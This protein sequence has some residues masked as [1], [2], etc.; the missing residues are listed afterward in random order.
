MISCALVFIMMACV[1]LPAVYAAPVSKSVDLTATVLE[2][3]PQIAIELSTNAL[4]FGSL[5]PGNTSDPQDLR[6]TN[7]GLKA[8]DVTATASDDG[9]EPL[10][11]AGLLIDGI[12]YCD[13]STTL[14]ASDLN[15]TNLALHV[16][17]NYVGRGAVS[18]GATFWAEE[19]SDKATVLYDGTVEMYEG[20]TLDFQALDG[21][22]YS[23]L[24]MNNDMG[25]LFLAG[26]QFGASD[27]YYPN[28]MLESINGIA[29]EPW[30]DS[31][32]SW[33]IFVNDQPANNGLH[34]NVLKNGDNV[35]FYYLQWDP[36]TYQPLVETA[37]YMVNI[38]IVF[39]E[40]A[41]VADFTADVTSGNVPLTV[42]FT[43][44]STNSPTSW[45]WDF[46]DG[47]TSTEQ[48]PSHTYA[49]PGSYMVVL[50]ATSAAGSSNAIKTGFVV[51]GQAITKMNWATFQGNNYHTGVTTEQAA[52]S[53]P[54]LQWSAKASSSG[55]AGFDAAPIVADGV[56]YEIS[57]K[58]SVAAYDAITGALLWE[59]NDLVISTGMGFQ[60][61]TPVYHDG[62]L[63][64]SVIMGTGKGLGIFALNAETGATLWSKNLLPTANVQPNTPIIYDGGRIYMGCWFSSA[65]PGTYWCLD[66]SNGN[67]VWDRSASSSKSYYWAGAAIVGNYLVYGEDSGNLISV[68]KMTGELVQE[69]NVN[70]LFGITSNS[71]RSSVVYS[72]AS[73]KLLFTTMSGYC[74]AIGFKTSDGTFD[75]SNQWS[76]NIGYSTS[77]PAVY[78]GKVYVGAGQFGTT[79]NYLYCLNEATGA[80][81][82]KLAVNGGVQ[83]SPVIS[84]YHD[85]GDGEVY[86]YFTT[87]AAKGH[88][89]CVDASGN[90]K[91]EYEPPTGQT[92]YVLQGVAIYDGKL[93][94][95]NDAGYIFAIGG[96]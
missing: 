42:Q 80:Q 36:V 4:N 66:A 62:V 94:F 95:G 75:T 6:V 88:A 40:A 79:G 19:H 87:N 41:P 90:V 30:S 86:I 5:Y 60:L 73:G 55:M 59:R 13:Y 81:E 38:D 85:D 47:A 15:D 35:K 48:N 34:D 37:R 20:W 57:Q 28:W 9:A 23:G 12:A 91:W 52:I 29:N 68:N 93:F 65:T 17:D 22:Y 27:Q 96:A 56:V 25:A 50:T 51:V 45:S 49:A 70:T 71:I 64:A 31:S 44:L 7:I 82:W 16:P 53:S 78:N 46:G 39:H 76:A 3:K 89:Y 32:C 92:Q 74:C 83:S 10:F 58:G 77:T 63:Y 43:D 54:S 84:T 24:S 67:T 1:L 26:V 72:E 2:P 21:T 14:A 61:S 69:A 18:G 11:T 33:A 8:V